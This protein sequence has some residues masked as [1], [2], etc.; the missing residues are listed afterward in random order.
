[1]FPR[2]WRR[3]LNEDD[4]L[5]LAIVAVAATVVGPLQV[6]ENRR[7]VVDALGPGLR[8]Q[9]C[10]VG[11]GNVSDGRCVPTLTYCGSDGF[12]VTVR[13]SSEYVDDIRIRSTPARCIGA[14]LMPGW[15]HLGAWHWAGGRVDAA[16]VPAPSA[17]WVRS[18][19]VPGEWA[20]ESST[21]P[22]LFVSA[23][24]RRGRTN[25]DMTRI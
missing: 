7:S 1:M 10:N 9:V 8:S 15:S 23:K 19:N 17:G 13:F 16:R 12:Q 11:N 21:V 6:G 22:G 2:C 4:M 25:F 20:F 18:G 3:E 24:N 14:R 5:F